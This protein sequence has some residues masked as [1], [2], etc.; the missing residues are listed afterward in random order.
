MGEG[1]EGAGKA[2]LS[3]LEKKGSSHILRERGWGGGG[4]KGRRRDREQEGRDG[5]RRRRVRGSIVNTWRTHLSPSHPSGRGSQKSDCT[6]LVRTARPVGGMFSY[7]LQTLRRRLAMTDRRGVLLKI[8]E[9][10]D[11]R[12]PLCWTEARFTLA[13]GA[14]GK[15]QALSASGGSR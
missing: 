13:R 2:P 14:E 8:Q 15:K 5:D 10:L 7:R 4:R 3:G 9:G 1:G 12:S 6:Q 11:S